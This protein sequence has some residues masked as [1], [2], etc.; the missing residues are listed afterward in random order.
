MRLAAERPHVQVSTPRAP[1]SLGHTLQQ[2]S[3]SGSRGMTGSQSAYVS[4]YLRS[5]SNA[6]DSA[7]LSL[8]LSLAPPSY[9]RYPERALERE[10]ARAEAR[11]DEPRFPLARIMSSASRF[12]FP[13]SPARAPVS[14]LRAAASPGAQ[15]ISSAAEEGRATG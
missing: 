13:E 10:L 2:R 3:C 7:P 5:I 1:G 11:L 8:P 4:G 14:I 12:P 9:I 15:G 6:T